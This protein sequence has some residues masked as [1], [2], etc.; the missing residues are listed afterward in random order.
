MSD[1][2][3]IHG[4]KGGVISPGFR[5]KRE[6]KAALEHRLGQRIVGYYWDSGLWRT[7][8]DGNVYWIRRD[9][10]PG[11]PVGSGL[12]HLNDKPRCCWY[13]HP[14]GSECP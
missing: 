6:A 1:Q 12:E 9:G 10:G 14:A 5:T 3:R 13:V 11:F 2:Y 7:V 8:V 4:F